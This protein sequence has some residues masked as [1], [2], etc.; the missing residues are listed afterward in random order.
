MMPNKVRGRAR[1]YLDR[2]LILRLGIF[3]IV[4]L[5]LFGVI[6][7]EVMQNTLAILWAVAGILIGFAG[8]LVASRIFRLK[9]DE[10]ASK[11]IGQIDWVGSVVLVLY[12]T[13]RLMLRWLFGNW[14]QGAALSSFIL[15]VTAGSMPGRLIGLVLGIRKIFQ[16]SNVP[17][18]K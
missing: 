11:V 6:V 8:G 9:W 16:A 5:I 18:D 13:F 2:R 12:L 1:Q 7:F 4:S 17:S 3:T 15:S 10:E 14:L